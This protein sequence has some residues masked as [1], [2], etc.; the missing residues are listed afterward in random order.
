MKLEATMVGIKF[1]ML[2]EELGQ[3]SQN[4]ERMTGAMQKLEQQ[5]NNER[6]K[7]TDTKIKNDELCK[8]IDA[9]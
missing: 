2:Q 3:S 8:Q 5:L 4:L 9:Y 1:N 6:Q 7:N